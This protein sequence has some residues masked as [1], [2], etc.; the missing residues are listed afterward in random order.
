MAIS[1]LS[2]S[3]HAAAVSKRKL[4]KLW[5]KT[6]IKPEVGFNGDYVDNKQV[7]A[8]VFGL[9]LGTEVIIPY[10]D[11]FK[12]EF[13]GGALLETGS[14]SSFIT[15]EYEPNRIWYL[16]NAQATYEPFS[17]LKLEAGAISQKEY[18]SPLLVS[19]SAFLGGRETISLNFT[20]NHRVY[21]KM[22]QTIPN[23]INLVQRIG[24]VEDNGTPY[25]YNEAI[26][27]DLEGDLLSI[28]AE[29]SQFR[30][31]SLA[32]GIANVSRNFGNSVSSGNNISSKFLYQYKGYNLAWEIEAS[33]INGM[34]I[35]FTGQWLYNSEAPESRN[36]GHI[37]GLGLSF[38]HLDFH[39]EQFR[40]ESDA[41]IA[42][43]NSKFY[44]HN[45]HEGMLYSIGYDVDDDFE[46]Q[47]GFVSS[48]LI[49]YNSLQSDT[50]KFFFDFT[51][52]F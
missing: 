16:K 24:V 14:N 28:K 9:K 46:F 50:E 43:Y 29:A 48:S 51:Q 2:L 27:I 39:I 47:V 22:E 23:N 20:K 38:G 35:E 1:S 31:E 33:P 30:F 19:G 44:S 25:Y 15:N 52:E 42:Y 5:E 13:G 32:A 7:E 8:R 21:L 41:S 45:N 37:Y 17:F 34:E 26:G 18:Y 11:E 3:I 10:S 6:Q 40:T 36:K 49:E 12:I 4:S